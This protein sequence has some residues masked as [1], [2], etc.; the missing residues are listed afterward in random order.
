MFAH[1]GTSAPLNRRRVFE[2]AGH[3]LIDIVDERHRMLSW[4]SR[5]RSRAQTAPLSDRVT[6]DF[7]ISVSERQL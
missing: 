6:E 4:N 2:S 1:S 3:I 5:H 7:T